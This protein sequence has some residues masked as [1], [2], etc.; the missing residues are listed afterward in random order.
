MR[1]RLPRRAMLLSRKLLSR[2][3]MSVK[4]LNLVRERLHRGSNLW[5]I[6][7]YPH[8]RFHMLMK[9][10][11]HLWI[12][13]KSSISKLSPKRGLELRSSQSRR[14][15]FWIWYWNKRFSSKNW[16]PAFTVVE[17]FPRKLY[18]L[19][20]IYRL[21]QT[22]KKDQYFTCYLKQYCQSPY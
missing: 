5:I 4:D 9:G 14:M 7:R 13:K 10:L 2:P 1:F 17:Y 12:L 15:I 21:Y 16:M 20:N 11:S 3:R 22:N 6:R 18:R 19:I 8:L